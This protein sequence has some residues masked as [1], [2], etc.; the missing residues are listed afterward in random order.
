MLDEGV[1]EIR[2]ETNAYEVNKETILRAQVCKK[3]INSIKIYMHI[4]FYEFSIFKHI[5]LKVVHIMNAIWINIEHDFSKTL[6][7]LWSVCPSELPSNIRIFKMTFLFNGICLVRKVSLYE[8]LSINILSMN[9][10]IHFAYMFEYIEWID[11]DRKWCRTASLSNIANSFYSNQWSS[12][13]NHS[14]T[15]LE[16]NKSFQ[17][18]SLSS[19]HLY[20]LYVLTFYWCCLGYI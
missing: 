17:C 9:F 14:S 7:F 13:L 15:A 8:K 3:R 4:G 16:C 12:S 18:S 10:P 2:P 11:K 20:F 6:P 19:V 1:L 5:C